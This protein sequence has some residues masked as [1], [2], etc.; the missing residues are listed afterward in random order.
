MKIDVKDTKVIESI[1]CT[2]DIKLDSLDE[3][4]A[5]KRVVQWAE[6]EMFRRTMDPARHADEIDI[7]DHLKKVIP[8]EE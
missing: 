7:I 2:L 1:H 8:N 4:R 3:I 6:A 5:F